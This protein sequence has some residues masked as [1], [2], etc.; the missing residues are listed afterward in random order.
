MMNQVWFKKFLKTKVVFEMLW[1]L[2]VENFNGRLRSSMYRMRNFKLAALAMPFLFLSPASADSSSECGDLISIDL[3]RALVSCTL[4]AEEGDILSQMIL[5]MMYGGTINLNG[6]TIEQN[7]V[8]AARW[9]RIPAEQG[10]TF[11]QSELGRMYFS[12]LGVEQ[13]YTLAF[14]WSSLAAE[15]GDT[16]SQIRLGLIF[17]YGLGV[18]QSSTRAVHWYRLA[19][20]QGNQYAQFNLGR[21]YH[22]GDGALLNYQEAMRWY[23]LAAK[24]GYGPAQSNIGSMYAGGHGVLQNYVLAHMWFNIAAANGAGE[25]AINNR[26]DISRRMTA[27]QI[28]RA[29]E[30]A[31]NCM[32]SDFQHPDCQIPDVSLQ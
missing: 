7:Y 16:N 26:D 6:Q 19:A 11:A 29:Q 10:N 4:A 1:S 3:Q 18:E 31:S 22:E 27:E 15:K 24:Q 23:V 17:D 2:R 30:K 14:Y 32:A 13:N 25:I 5:G 8:E 20:E 28:A 21:L 12:G 9:Y